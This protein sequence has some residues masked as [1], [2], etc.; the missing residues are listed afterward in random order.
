MTLAPVN[1][2]RFTVS[3]VAPA[4][5]SITAAARDRTGSPARYAELTTSEWMPSW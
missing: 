3:S 4:I 2:P 1:R 5:S